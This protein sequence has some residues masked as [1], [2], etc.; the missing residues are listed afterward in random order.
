MVRLWEDEK[1]F[2]TRAQVADHVGV[3][4]PTVDLVLRRARQGELQIVYEGA[5]TP[6]RGRRWIMP[7]EGIRAIGRAPESTAAAFHRAPYRRRRVVDSEGEHT[8]FV[9]S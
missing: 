3:R 4:V 7:S 5:G 6:L 9:A 8:E 1:P 2:P